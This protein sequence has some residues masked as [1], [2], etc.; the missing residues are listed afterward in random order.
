[1]QPP[2]LETVPVNRRSFEGSSE[3][4]DTRSPEHEAARDVFFGQVVIN[5]ARWF[6]IAAGA[7][8]VLINA[9]STVQLGI[10]IA[11]IVG[12]MAL[13]F[14]LHGRRLAEK[15][16]NI[17]LIGVSSVIDVA[18]ITLVVLFGLGSG[19]AGLKNQFYVAFY[20][21]V[22]A[23]TFV[24]PRKAAIG[25]TVATVAL[26]AM[27]CVVAGF[28]SGADIFANTG[29]AESLATRLIALAAVGGLGTFFWRIQ[30][31]RRRMAQEE[32]VRL[33]M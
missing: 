11:P 8:M 2:D 6:A 26:Y 28:G 24:M 1:V 7:V 3:M 12:M 19:T 10:G 20:P 31:S 15:P 32:G 23:F 14:Y 18:V 21:V 16:A 27:A 22:L 29:D 4:Q 5:W 30:R 17:G 25:F 33:P 9:E 13:N